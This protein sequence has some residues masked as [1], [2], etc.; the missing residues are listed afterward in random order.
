MATTSRTRRNAPTPAEAATPKV[1]AAP[2]AKPAARKSPARKSADVA[3]PASQA[4]PALKKR[5]AAKPTKPGAQALPQPVV[6]AKKALGGKR[7]AG[8]P[9]PAAARKSAARASA[10]AAAETLLA[11]AQSA[12]PGAA[13]QSAPAPAGAETAAKRRP[14]R[15][16]ASAPAPVP[17]PAQPP[18]QPRKRARPA[19]AQES[20]ALPKASPPPAALPVAV[21]APADPPVAAPGRAPRQERPARPKAEKPVAPPAGRSQR[22]RPPAPAALIEEALLPAPAVA[23]PT[24]P[25]HS[26]IVLV[27]G[28]Q[29]WLAWQPGHACPPALQQAA[30]LRLDAQSHFAPDDDA[31]LPLL[32]RMA[33]D[34]D[35]PLQVDEAV[36]PQLA[37]DR[38]ARHRLAVLEAA[39][40]EGPSSA[41]LSALL[42]SP[43]PVYQ[44]EGALFAVVAGRALIA[45]ERG[46]GKSVQAIAA[47]ALWQRHFGV[48]RIL[49]LCAAA[50]RAVW[51]RAWRRFAGDTEPQLVDGGLHQ[52]QS[53]WSTPAAVRI[54]APEAL[55]S[56]AAHLA[57]WAPDLIIVDEPQQLALRPADWASLQSPQAL[58]LCGA[59][60]ADQPDLMGSIVGWLDTQRQGPLAA[61]H[62]LQAASEQGRAL[63]ESDIERLTAGLSR[64][65]LQRQR[66]DLHDQLPP[67]VHSERLLALAPG[68][69]EAHELQLT[70]VRRWLAGWQ[71]SGY[72]SDTDQWRLA[73]ALRS[74]RFACHRADPADPASA[75]A[76]SSV[77]A[78]AGQLADW[79]GTG[80]LQVAVLCETPADREQLRERLDLHPGLALL[81]PSDPMPATLDAVVQLGV[82][83]RTRRSPAGARGQT[84]P[85]QQWLYLVAQDSLDGG[86]FDTLDARLDLPRT[87]VDGGRGFL[88]GERLSDWLQ[89]VLAAVQAIAVP[90][91]QA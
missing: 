5:S 29:R 40:P 57:Q 8:K 52:R 73:L 19:R 22:K 48:R 24:G 66:T 44:S 70:Q 58:V 83:W 33:A 12:L 42:R 15:K 10:P 87:L 79:A 62:E 89:A 2:A 17:P 74:L 88:Q 56:D 61:L 27:D 65:M 20:A 6:A 38:D 53:L 60:L 37:A 76:E 49:V 50:Q 30:A 72:L 28:D 69:R 71:Q 55:A 75:L 84:L 35:H 32:L 4:L 23:A 80:A 45:D 13:L 77:Q 26:A 46:L 25:A 34:L 91:P 3:P 51:Q 11:V 78:L 43:L 85:G 18:V 64:L 7:T 68:Q 36:W 41:G 67:L 31:A 86:L 59:P 90:T 1:D 9:E 16:P 63:D 14:A 39:Y 47:A 21:P 81:L 82:P 54:L